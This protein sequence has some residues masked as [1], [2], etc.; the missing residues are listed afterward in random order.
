[1]FVS[2]NYAY[3]Y[4]KTSWFLSSAANEIPLGFQA[5]W[6][7]V[8]STVGPFC[9]IVPTL[10]PFFLSLASSLAH[11]GTWQTDAPLGDHR[12]S[13]LELVLMFRLLLQGHQARSAIGLFCTIKEFRDMSR[14]SQTQT[15]LGVSSFLVAQYRSSWLTAMML[16]P[17]FA[18]NAAAFST[19]LL[20]PKLVR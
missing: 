20:A 18:S 10:T 13:L 8:R 12:K 5:T 14:Q 3:G 6:F 9:L 1:M 4:T 17:L 11:V 7:T 2:K 19:F 16:M 15:Q